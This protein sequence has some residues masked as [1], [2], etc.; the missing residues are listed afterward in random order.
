METF[1]PHLL[2][3]MMMVPGSNIV[4]SVTAMFLLLASIVLGTYN[5][6]LTISSSPSYYTDPFFSRKPREEGDMER[7]GRLDPTNVTERLIC[8]CLH[9]VCVVWV[10]GICSK[11]NKRLFCFMCES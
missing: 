11:W 1:D 2:L 6:L 10:F 9:K 5:T 8:T 4:S 7:A 3:L